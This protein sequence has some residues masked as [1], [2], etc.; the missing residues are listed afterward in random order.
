MTDP[1]R[2]PILFPLPC[3]I[4]DK[5]WL[6]TDSTLVQA[7]IKVMSRSE[8]LFAAVR[9]AARDIC[10]HYSDEELTA[11]GLDA[12]L[13]LKYW[14]NT[15]FRNQLAY[16]GTMTYDAA[17]Q[18][19]MEVYEKLLAA[20]NQGATFDRFA[21]FGTMNKVF[22]QQCVY[23]TMPDGTKKL[24]MATKEDG[25]LTASILQSVVDLDCAYREKNNKE[26]RGYVVN[27]VEAVGIESSLITD[28]S[29][30]PCTTSD[31]SLLT[32]YLEVL[33]DV[34]PSVPRTSY[35]R[36]IAD[37]AYYSA[38]TEKLAL[39]KG[40][41]L[42]C[43]DL[44]G[45]KPDPWLAGFQ[46]D[47]KSFTHCP[48]GNPVM[49]CKGPVGPGTY[50]IHMEPSACHNCPH[51][52]TCRV[53]GKRV[54]TIKLTAGQVHRA[55]ILKGMT[56]EEGEAARKIRSRTEGVQSLIKNRFRRRRLRFKGLHKNRQDMFC[57][58]AA[59]NFDRY[60]AWSKGFKFTKDNLFLQYC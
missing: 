12:D 60:Y 44:A 3:G 7:N 36:L 19:H 39:Q 45:N 16:Y 10:R 25:Q 17:C 2:M 23:E 5:I 32:G 47:G 31:L 50:R 1:V 43:T 13:L 51:K 54:A 15:T 8:L 41:I 11:Y 18:L 29:I 28:I 34:D 9:I 57:V 52:D 22:T 48:L 24:R 46:F 4:A 40:Y 33:P 35:H 21:S 30:Q 27:S 42:T 55:Q 6:L 37:G 53:E 56:E 14:K 49:D 58:G 26:Y 38:A 59:M 20:V